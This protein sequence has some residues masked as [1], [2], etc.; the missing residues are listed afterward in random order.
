MPALTTLDAAKAELGVDG[1][2]DDARLTRLIDRASAAIVSY[3]G[4]DLARSD[5]IV[6]DVMPA[7]PCPR[8]CLPLYPDV[9]VNR[10]MYGASVLDPASWSV[11]ARNGI[12]FLPP[13]CHAMPV[14]VEY[15]G[16]YALPGSDAPTLPA[17]IE[18]ACL[19][20]VRAL[21]TSTGPG[22]RDPMLRSE[23]IQGVGAT[24]WLDPQAGAGGL[25]PGVAAALAP[26]RP[27]GV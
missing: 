24:S 1:T 11:D 3:L 5:A 7:S 14:A 20:T 17:D 22:A 9:A 23:S 27:V 25:P 12:L 15:T 8:L 4:R 13:L 19:D 6:M 10:V 16:G 18:G 21:W 26:Y 2:A